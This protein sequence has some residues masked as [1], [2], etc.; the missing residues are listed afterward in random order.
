MTLR[1]PKGKGRKELE[2]EVRADPRIMPRPTENDI[3]STTEQHQIDIT[4]I[5]KRHRKTGLIVRL[6]TEDHAALQRDSERRGIGM[7]AIVR[8]LVHR[9]L[10]GAR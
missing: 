1:N 8:E 2:D 10:K 4:S 3:E 7:S 6:S 5:S 9:Y